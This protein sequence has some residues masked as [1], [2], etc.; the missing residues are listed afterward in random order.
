MTTDF[1]TS[2]QSS[3]S[4][5]SI[6]N[7]INRYK[8]LF[9]NSPIPIQETNVKQ[10]ASELERLRNIGITDIET[11]IKE[12]PTFVSTLYNQSD[13]FDVNQATLQLFEA[14]SKEEYFEKFKEVLYE[15]CLEFFRLALINVFKNINV[16]TK[17]AELSTFK[18]T[19]IW[20][21]IKA[22]YLSFSGNEMINYTLKDI[23]EKKFKDQAISLINKRMVKGTSQEHLNNLVLALSEVFDITH[24]FIASPNKELTF[25]TTLAFTA[26][27][28]VHPSVTY[29]LTKAPCLK[30][31]QTKKPVIYTD[32]VDKI[33]PNNNAIKI[34]N[35]K[36]YLG[37]PLFDDKGEVIG[38]FSFIN[39]KAITNLNLVQE[40]MGLYATWASSEF[41]RLKYQKAQEE[42]EYTLNLVAN[43]IGDIFYAFDLEYNVIA[44]NKHAKVALKSAYQLDLAIGKKLLKARFEDLPTSAKDD[45]RHIQRALKGEIVQQYKAFNINGVT[46]HFLTTLSPIKDSND[47]VKGCVII[48]KDLTE[49][50]TAEETLMQKNLT[51]EQQLLSLEQKNNEL[52]KYIES[53]SQLENFAYIASHDLKAPIRTIVSFSQLLQRSLRNNMSESTQEYLNFI[54]SASINMKQLIEDLL[55]YSRIDNVKINPEIVETNDLLFM[56]QHE[57]SSIIEEKNPIIELK[58]IPDRIKADYTK[59]KQVFQNLITN[60]IKFHKK[61]EPPKIEISCEEE[62]DFWKFSIK[63]SGIGINPEYFERIFVLFQKLHTNKEYNGTG[64]GLAICKKVIEQHKGQIWLE[65]EVN[66]GTTFHFTISKFL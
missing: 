1:Q 28:E 32:H 27:K 40:I 5:E 19:K 52:E 7:Q 12:N 36:S 26:L 34:W 22:T 47:K 56:I 54:I 55:E 20:V 29:N 59:I 33:Y 17:E 61:G 60:A 31:Y 51:I 43:N 64:L 21:E 66:I 42:S 2:N 18:G 30:I 62:H 45:V 41:Q 8:F 63:D 3:D 11:Y 16:V 50:K 24:A 37:F 6:D 38:N 58:N 9:D 15:P 39:N 48:A 23:T 10:V 46:K 13:I 57:L 53:N 49:L 65:S 25:N 35:G 4:L 14:D 44:F